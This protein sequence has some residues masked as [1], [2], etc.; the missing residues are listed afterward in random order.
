M[1]FLLALLTLVQAEWLG[2]HLVYLDED[3][4]RVASESCDPILTDCAYLTFW[5][6]LTTH[7]IA[8]IWVQINYFGYKEC[9]IEPKYFYFKTNATVGTWDSRT[10]RKYWTSSCESLGE[11]AKMLCE[12]QEND[13]LVTYVRPQIVV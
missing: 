11:C 4:R 8:Y 9:N 7:N 12:Y 3:F 5:R 6:Y 13:L 1:L 2:T 10:K